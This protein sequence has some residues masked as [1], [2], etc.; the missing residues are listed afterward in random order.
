LL[1]HYESMKDVRVWSDRIRAEEVVV[2]NNELIYEVVIACV[3]DV[4]LLY[5]LCCL[6]ANYPAICQVFLQLLVDKLQDDPRDGFLVQAVS[7]VVEQQPNA[8]GCL[9]RQ[10]LEDQPAP[11]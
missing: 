5:R 2:E 10:I 7:L 11:G 3:P 9:W 1:S 8:A 6:V 4:L